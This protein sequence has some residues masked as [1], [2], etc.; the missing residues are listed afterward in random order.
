MNIKKA[1]RQ[2]VVCQ[3][4]RNLCNSGTVFISII[5]S[6]ERRK[7]NDDDD[8]QVLWTSLAQSVDKT[9]LAMFLVVFS[10]LNE[11]NL[12]TETFTK[13]QLSP[14]PFISN[15]RRKEKTVKSSYTTR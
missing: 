5:Y 14:T 6:N 3:K 15:F 13:F 9:I 10:N 4:P 12:M 11:R 8:D 7:K 2:M 1:E